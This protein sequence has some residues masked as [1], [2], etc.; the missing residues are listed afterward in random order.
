MRIWSTLYRHRWV[1]SS[2]IVR[3]VSSRYAGSA[4]GLLWLILYPL[5]FLA[6]YSYVFLFVFTLQAQKMPVNEYLILI[7]CALI[8]FL[9]ISECMATSTSSVVANRDIV[10]GTLFPAELLPVRYAGSSMAILASGFTLLLPAAW[11][12]GF[13]H[14]TQ[15]LLP[16]LM[17]VQ[18]LFMMGIAW[19][20][21][22]IYV[23][24][25]DF[26]Q[27]VSI[28]IMMLML[29]SPIAFDRTMLPE[30]MRAMTAFN[31]LFPYME[32]YR[33]LCLR[34]EIPLGDV[35]SVV[36][37]ALVTFHVGAFVFTRLKVAFGD[38]L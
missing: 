9:A 8:P 30:S 17:L 28:L 3:E 24:F 37:I 21:A 36:I 31:P 27:I 1:L 22:T 7:Y 12:Q 16:L 23:F 35:V 18:F 2:M 29:L 26:G 25:R 11:S 33:S 13:V 34:G 38:Y 32:L 20:C 19:I 6:L 10:T 4:F 15:L 14:W 5:L